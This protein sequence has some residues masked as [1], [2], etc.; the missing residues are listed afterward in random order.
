MARNKVCTKTTDEKG[1]LT[2]T[3]SDD[4]VIIVDPN[5]YPPEI[6]ENLKS[7]G[8]SQ[9]LGDSF[10]GVTKPEEARARV[11]QVHKGLMEN[12]W[13]TRTAG[14]PRSNMLVEALAVIQK[15]EVGVMRAFVEG[16]DDDTKK[17]VR[18]HPE[19]K[20]KMS[21]MKAAK[22]KAAAEKDDI[23]SIQSLLET[24]TDA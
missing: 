10:A 11:A 5:K 21:E 22:D 7:H 16:L 24:K 6:Q 17:S 12:K 9:K 8:A 3:F 2:F 1:V 23:P 20:A 18:N 13:T 14:E 4:E 15:V 19:V